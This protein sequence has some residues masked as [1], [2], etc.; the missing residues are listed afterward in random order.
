MGSNKI[1]EMP[2]GSRWNKWTILGFS[3][4]A[5]NSGNAH[6]HARC[7]CGTESIVNGSKVRIGES[8]QCKG[9]SSRQNGRKGLYSKSRTNRQ[10]HYARNKKSDLYMIRCGNYVKIGVSRD[11]SRRLKDL[12]S[13]NP[14]DLELIYH[15]IDEGSDEETWHNI[16]KHRHHR[17]E[18]FYMPKEGCEI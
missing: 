1:I 16:F 9:C 18:W 3:H 4:K 14:L 11:V 5:P 10:S 13:S 17:G 8:T 15:G 12:Q 6:Y 7:E 2:V